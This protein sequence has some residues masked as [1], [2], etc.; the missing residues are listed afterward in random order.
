MLFIVLGFF[1]RCG[2]STATFRLND[3]HNRPR[4]GCARRIAGRL[5]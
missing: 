4:R 3:S 2:R 5:E 1:L